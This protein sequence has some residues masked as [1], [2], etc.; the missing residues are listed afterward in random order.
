V[1]QNVLVLPRGVHGM[2]TEAYASVLRKR[3]PGATVWS[4]RTEQEISDRLPE[5]TVVTGHHMDAGQINRAPNLELFQALYAGTDHLP[6]SA[7]EEAEVAVTSASGVHGPNVAEHAI[8]SALALTRQF[9]V[10]RRRAERRE[11]RH[12]QAHEMA[13]GT[14]TVVGLGPIGEAIVRRLD[15]FDVDTIGIRYTP[16]KGGPTDEVIGFGDAA[17]ASA[18]AR[19]TCFSPVRSPRRPER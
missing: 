17:V 1:N 13:G 16:E 14:A 11:W 3:L 19:S 9:H 10:A 18:P 7:F 8:G 2:P 5:A 4:P 6:L 15:G 12:Y